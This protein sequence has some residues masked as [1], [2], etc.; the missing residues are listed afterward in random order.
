MKSTVQFTVINFLFFTATQGT[1]QVTLTC[2][3]DDNLGER[4]LPGVPGKRGPVGIP[5]DR[6]VKGDKGDKGEPGASDTWMQEFRK[7]QMRI[8]DLED[9]LTNK[10]DQRIINL[11]RTGDCQD[12]FERGMTTSGVKNVAING[13]VFHRRFD[14]SEN[15]YR[16]WEDY[17]RG[18]GRVDSE[19]WLGLNDLHQLTKNGNYRLR[20]DIEDFEN[21]RAFAEY[22]SFQVGSEDSNYRLT[23]TGYSGNAGD[24]LQR[25]N[26]IPFSTK[27]RDLDRYSGN[28]AT[29]Y[30]E[31]WWYNHCHAVNLNGLYLTGGQITAKGMVW[32]LWKNSHYSLKKAEMKIKPN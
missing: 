27:D 7:L 2:G 14:G 30:E 26:G 8:I 11:T 29:S 24:A 28:C 15:F 31:A 4:G 5:G 9:Q 17:Q 20:V 13:K 21:N 16:N 6:G 32:Y 12:L 18:F 22:S 23:A 3:A 1:R 19:Y 10:I 25:H